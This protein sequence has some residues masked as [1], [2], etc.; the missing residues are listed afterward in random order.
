MRALRRPHDPAA[1][2]YQEAFDVVREQ[3]AARRCEVMFTGTG[4][5]EINAYHSRTHADLRRPHPGSRMDVVTC[6][7]NSHVY[8]HDNESIN[9]VFA[10]FAAHARP[11]A[12]LVLCS[13]VTPITRTEPTTATVDTPTGPATVT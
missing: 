12:L 6:M 2:F 4:G 13:P 10:T 9:R 3:A 5:D 8:V 11:G 1:A 7:R